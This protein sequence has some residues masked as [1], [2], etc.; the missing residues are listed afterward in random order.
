[1][2][3]V[4]AVVVASALAGLAL[5]GVLTLWALVGLAALDALGSTVTEVQ[6]VPI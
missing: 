2:T 6:R 4:R 1:M 3:L 5:M